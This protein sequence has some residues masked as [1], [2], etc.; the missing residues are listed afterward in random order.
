MTKM[1]YAQAIDFAIDV[2]NPDVDPED[3][4]FNWEEV[5]E[6]LE[7]LKEQLAKRS[8]SKTPTK[9]QKLNEGIMDTIEDALVAVDKPVTVTE[10][11][12]SDEGLKNLTNQKVSALLRKMVEANRVVK[13][14]EGKKALFAVAE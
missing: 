13:T 12:A 9:T 14:I 6:K 10:L 3:D 2:M 11:I 7:A 1:T 5:R 8:T 4:K